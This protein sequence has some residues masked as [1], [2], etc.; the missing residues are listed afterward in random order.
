MPPL[1]MSLRMPWRNSATES[2]DERRAGGEGQRVGDD[3]VDHR[4]QAGDGEA[5]HHRVADVLLAHHA[6][7]EEPET[8]DRHHQHERHRGQHPG[9]VAAARRAI[10]QHG[11]DGGDGG[12]LSVSGTAAAARRRPASPAERAWPPRALPAQ[13]RRA[14]AAGA[15]GGVGRRRVGLG[16]GATGAARPMNGGY[17]QRRSEAREYPCQ[18]HGSGLRNGMG[19]GASSLKARPCPSRPCGSSPPSRGCRR[20]SCRRRSGRCAPQ[21]RSLRPPCRRRPR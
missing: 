9:R 11:R 15:A 10:R 5:R 18:F 7:V 8:R 1:L 19:R 21:R 17:R 12:V 3:G 14:A 4:H 16:H 13:R 2:A 20:R 6:A